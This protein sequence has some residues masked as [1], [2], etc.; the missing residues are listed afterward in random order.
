MNDSPS[1]R[2][3]DSPL[4]AYLMLALVALL[5]A[6]N[7]NVARATTQEV[8]PLALT[9]WRLL[10]S[11]LV[12][13]PFALRNTW[14]NRRVVIRHFWLLNL[15][16]LLSMATFNALVYMGMQYTV[17]STPTSCRGPCR[18]AFFCRG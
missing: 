10:L 8:P 7:T 4:V 6:A 14:R 11:A 12:F 18:S 1:P 17:G 13:A 9:F 15:L 2:K 16:A 5:W 3:L